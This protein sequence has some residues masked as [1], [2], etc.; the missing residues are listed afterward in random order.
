[1]KK[2]F[3]IFLSLP[4]Y[5]Y[6]D[7]VESNNPK[8]IVI[9]GGSITEII[10]DLNEEE[11]ILAVDITSNYPLK[12]KKLPSVGYVRALSTEGLLS[13][14]PSLVLGEEDMGPPLVLS[15]LEIV[16]VDVR[17]IEDD[18]SSSGIIAKVSCISK[19]INAKKKNTDALIQ[20]LITN[21]KFLDQNSKKNRR[22]K[23]ILLILSFQGTS[24]IVAGHS[25]SGHGFINLLGA[26]NTMQS[27]EGWKPI[28]T[29]S[30]LKE[31]PDY[32]IITSRGMTSFKSM[33]SLSNHPALKYTSAAL[34]KNIFSLDGMSMLGFG[35]RTLETAIEVSKKIYGE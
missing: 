18:F 33:D 30:I 26:K 29:E 1:M 27:V 6:S 35:P 21:K 3:L 10:Y 14:N 7:C 5:L 2:L 12:A 34:N 16:G 31:D 20:R 4:I 24:P 11:K 22:K 15:Q 9:A 25:T 8:K 17:I 23:S 28:S 13:L 32:I 19:I